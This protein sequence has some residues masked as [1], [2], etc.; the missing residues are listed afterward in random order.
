MQDAVRAKRYDVFVSYK[1]GD[2][3]ARDVL[4][5]A[6]EEEG[7]EVFW[8]AKI[9]VDYWR[10]KLR[11]E[12]RNS[13][14]VIVLWS[15]EAAASEEVKVEAAGALML[16][17]LMS[18]PIEDKRVVPKAYRDTNLHAFHHWADEA[19]R[20]PQLA[21][22]LATVRLITGGPSQPEAPAVAHTIPVD[23][24]GLPGAP[25]KLIGRDDEMEML[26]DAWRGGKVNAVVLHALG[27]AG[28]SALLRAF[29]NERLAAGGDGA[30]R[31][32]GWSAYSLSTSE[33]GRA[34]ADGFITKA[35]GDFGYDG[36]SLRDPVARARALARLIQR[37]RVLL[38]LDG[39]E[40]LQ[41]PPGV[42][43]GRFKDKGLA[44]LTKTL[45]AMNPGLVVLTSRQEV[46]EL[47]GFGNDLVI[48][49]ALEKLSESAGADLLVELGVTGR[50]RDL[51]DAVRELDGHA[52]CVTVLGTFLAE[53]CGGDVKLRN[54]FK[55]G[56]IILTPEEQRST[57]KTLIPAK[58]AAKVMAGY[59]E[60]FGKL[61]KAN[62]A[63]QGGPERALLSLLGLFDRPADGAAVDMLLAERILGLTDALFVEPTSKRWFGV[64]TRTEFRNLT[65]GERASRLREAK[66][67]LRKLRLLAKE[68]PKDRGSLDAHPMVRA[69][70][71]KLLEQAALRSAQIAHDR[72]YHHYASVAPDLP[73]TLEEMQPLF[74]A[75]GHGVK[76]GRVQEAYDEILHRR[77]RRKYQFY[78]TNTV[79][80]F[81]AELAASSDFFDKLWTE[82]RS[83]LQ[84]TA[85]SQLL[86]LAAHDLTALGRFRE[87]VASSEAHLAL[88][89]SGANWR[90]AASAGGVL[91]NALLSLGEV[92]RAVEKAQQAVR[93]AD[94]SNDSNQ[95]WLRRAELARAVAAWGQI[96]HASTLFAE[97]EN[98]RTSSTMLTSYAG[99][100]YGD[101]LLARGKPEK[102][103]ERGRNQLDLAPGAVDQGIGAH[104]VGLGWLLTGRAQDA[105]GHPDAAAALDNAVEALRDAGQEQLVPLALLARAAY[106]RGWAAAGERAL[107]P[108]VRD[109]LAEVEDI[110]EPEMRLYLS[111]LALERARLA[112]DVPGAFATPA[113]AR[114]EAVHQTKI[115]ADLIAATGY[116]RRDGELRELQARLASASH[117]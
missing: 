102:A 96:D 85:R 27:G 36:P 28:K 39:L 94:D 82:P 11:D 58:R 17:K 65:P 86:N 8:D 103:L 42:N 97:A 110:A 52:L 33:Q 59:L 113:E 69:Y 24:G 34:D 106:R 105:L 88:H 14:L 53:V 43:K 104:I 22:I 18:A 30:E 3:A 109:D 107:L 38:L 62:R 84:L 80:A 35:L 20:A 81:G 51:E 114:Q 54:R 99:Y 9:G 79:G 66:S 16:Q 75:I 26:R 78:L 23:L 47:E 67:R 13:K 10:P 83:V 71:G 55:F 48:H 112:L 98:L 101:L 92:E 19:A 29:V 111:D 7:Y 95:R 72:L 2:D 115:A 57:D 76:A 64:F 49:H 21:K 12:I 44:A 46:P 1:H 45:A 90:L 40:P 89:V 68:D 117:P 100:H 116:H 6:L 60:Q 91:S 77:I 15:A 63:G 56:N 74:H 70:F 50:Q 4:V 25:P 41:D 37:E 5:T 93:L 87:A 73:D 108:A 61:A 31:I 32:Y